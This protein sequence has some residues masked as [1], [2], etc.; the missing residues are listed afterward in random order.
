MPAS[1]LTRIRDISPRL[2]VVSAA[3][4]VERPQ[5]LAEAEI[6]YTHHIAADRVASAPNLKWVQTLGAGVEWLLTPEIRQRQDLIVTNTSG[7]H[8]QPIAEHVFGFVL[9]FAHQLHRATRQQLA[10]NWDSNALRNDVTTLSGATLGIVGLGAIGRR[11]AEIAGSFGMRVIALKRSPGASPGVERVFGP[12]QLTPFLKEAEYVIN[13]LPLTPQTRG[14]F[15]PAE[16]AAMRS[17]AVF[18][19]IGRG[20]T[21]Q[22]E[23]LVDALKSGRI[24]GAALDVTDPEPL[25]QEHAL[26][27]LE[28]V[29]LT[30]HYSGAHPGYMQRA[31]A[32]FLE[33]L[34]SY[35]AERPLTHV[36]D[37]RAGY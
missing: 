20:G 33:N 8:A 35:L 37:K 26:W 6:L 34:V 16:F 13:T 36:V 15:G 19:N 5:W 27:G 32:I 14:L 10:H 18:V 7:I 21:V 22:T 3:Q 4:L 25:P 9:M 29:I 30:P 2:T 28:N 17:D 23:A 11:I 31:S 1:L 12:G 24:A